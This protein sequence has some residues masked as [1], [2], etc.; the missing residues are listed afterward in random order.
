MTG[1]NQR[2]V[3][4]GKKWAVKAQGSS[5]PSATFDTKTEATSRARQIAKKYNSKVI[6]HREN[7]TTQK[8]SGVSKKKSVKRKVVSRAAAKKK[9][10][11]RTTK[12]KSVKR[13]MKKKTARKSW[14]KFWR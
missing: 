5:R 13:V 2:V 10:A 3:P 4:Y 1:P 6:S 9:Q 11:S 7:G 8:S 14:W 12:K